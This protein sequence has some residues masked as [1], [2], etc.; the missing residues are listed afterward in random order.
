[1][2]RTFCTIALALTCLGAA[3]RADDCGPLKQI[4]SLDMTPLPGGRFMVPVTINGTQQQM[5]LAT[6]GG[7][8]SLN[9]ESAD[10]MGIQPIDASH[11]KLL[12]SNGAT[13]QSYAQIDFQLGAI[14]DPKLQLIVMP[15]GSGNAPPFVGN[16]AGDFLS[17]NDVEMDFAD[18]KLNIF[19]KDHC[20]G[21]VLYWHPAAVAVLPI[22]L[23]M[24]TAVDSRTGFRRYSYRGS[25]IIV[26]VTIDGKTF[27]AAINTSSPTSQ[28]STQTAKFI[29]GVTADSPGSVRAGNGAASDPDHTPFTHTFSSL[30]FDT[31]T[32]TN[33]HF[34]VYPD[35]TGAND[36]NNTSRTDMRVSRVDDNIGG[37][38]TIGMDVLRK[39][40]LYVAYGE[41]T[42]YVTP[43][44]APVPPSPAANVGA[45][46]APSLMK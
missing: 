34:F 39:L 19:S 31:V 16:L 46:G 15:S 17:L 22:I 33:P 43:A 28:M 32:V 26:P 23:Q 3:A 20:P 42:L 29:F 24:P 18:R 36:P 38:I 44:T 13:S 11:I 21:H 12:S 25:H 6:A 45:Q 2:I 14:H 4:S 1:M 5:E 9:Q 35:L 30:T 40:R 27:K 37:D 10:K 7:I 8:T 41:R